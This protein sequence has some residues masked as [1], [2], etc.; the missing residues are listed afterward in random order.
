MFILSGNLELRFVSHDFYE[1]STLE[2][3][4]IR[5]LLL[6]FGGNNVLEARKEDFVHYP[7]LFKGQTFILKLFEGENGADI[8]ENDGAPLKL[9]HMNKLFNIVKYLVERGADTSEFKDLESSLF[10]QIEDIEANNTRNKRKPQTVKKLVENGIDIHQNNQIDLKEASEKSHLDIAK[11]LIKK[12]S[13]IHSD[14]GWALGMAS[15]SEY[16]EVVK[17]LVEN[18]ANLNVDNYSVL[19]SVSKNKHCGVVE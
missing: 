17:Y 16:S 3:I 13:D 6:K 2:S 1:I 5:F 10:N 11:Y 7:N 9:S 8:N 18:G 14:Q 19:I 15:K 12:G 4:R